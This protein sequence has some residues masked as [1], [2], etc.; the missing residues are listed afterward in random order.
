MRAQCGL[1]LQVSQFAASGI[2]YDDLL[3]VHGMFA[4]VGSLGA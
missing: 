2:L 4:A 3:P 1:L